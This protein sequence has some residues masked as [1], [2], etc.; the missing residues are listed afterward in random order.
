MD[1]TQTPKP[2]VAPLKVRLRW[3]MRIGYVVGACAL[4]IL[5]LYLY[6]RVVRGNFGVV[7]PGK[8][9]R[10]AQPNP[11]QLKDW[12]RQYGIKT[13]INLRGTTPEYD[14]PKAAAQ[15]GAGEVI[16]KLSATH[17]PSAQHMR[18]LVEAI[19]NSPQ[20]ILLHCKEGADRAGL[21]SV[22]AAMCVGHQS[23]DEAKKEL[24]ILHFHVDSRQQSIGG[25]LDQYEDCCARKNLPHGGWDEF[26]NWAMNDYCDENQPA[27]SHG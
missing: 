24:T 5:G 26:R 11:D 14:E 1:N 19:E 18:E 2:A 10:S 16:V 21:A 25:I 13:I 27:T 12:V 9:Y 22:L 15:A 17:H 20:P 23:Y 3:P 6:Q 7:V 8:V 4:C